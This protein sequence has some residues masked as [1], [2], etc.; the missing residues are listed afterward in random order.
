MP[1]FTM[2]QLV[3]AGVH[4]GHHTRR[5]NPRMKPYIFGARNNIHILDLELSVPMLHRALDAIR[6]VAAGGGR[7]LFVGTKPAAAD[8]LAES[9]KACGQYYVNHRWLGGM[10][11]NW[12]T[13]SQSLDRLRQLEERLASD[14]VGA[15]TKKEVLGLERD[16]DRLENTLGGIKEMADLPDMLFVVDTN[17]EAIAVA[18]ARVLKIPV[19]AICDS[20]ANPEGVDY[21]I[22]GNDDALR[23]ITLYCDL[24]ASA[25]VEGLKMEVMQKTDDAGTISDLD[26]ETLAHA[27]GSGTQTNAKTDAKTDGK[28]DGKAKTA[29][30]GTD[31]NNAKN[32][33]PAKT[34]KTGKT[35]KATDSGQANGQAKSQ[36]NV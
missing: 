6:E 1:D 36:A 11:T 8:I 28:T 31:A 7:I 20:N 21:V 17:K 35:S 24:V 19:V 16:R 27:N 23:A 25:V 34:D 29:K 14:E 10:L 3:E 22:P 9:A 15:L 12:A 18:E 30:T 33:K 2:R 32:A 26:E 13:V 4:F 5:W